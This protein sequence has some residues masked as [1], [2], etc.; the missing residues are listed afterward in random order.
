M[1][2]SEPPA[3][4][5]KKILSKVPWQNRLVASITRQM[6][7][8]TTI[9]IYSFEEAVNF[10]RSCRSDYSLDELLISG[11]SATINYLDLSALANWVEDVLGDSELSQALR[12]VVGG[13]SENPLLAFREKVKPVLE[14]MEQRLEQCKAK[15]PEAP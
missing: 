2:L 3:E 10:L 5:A 9:D 12:E 7:G 8:I 13:E 15:L 1:T 14:L 11:S 4:L 6:T